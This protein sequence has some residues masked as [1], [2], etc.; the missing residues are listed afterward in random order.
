MAVLVGVPIEERDVLGRDL[1]EAGADFAESSGEQAAE[2]EAADHP[3]FV[4]PAEAIER[5]V[6]TL[7]RLVAREVA[8]RAFERLE[9]QVEGPAGGGAEQAVRVVH[10]A[11]E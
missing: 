6:E 7:P 2:T 8:P 3:F 9:G 10:R 11:Q 4:A 5:S 1:D